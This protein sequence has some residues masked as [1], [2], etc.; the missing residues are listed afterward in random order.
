MVQKSI[1]I[2]KIC[3]QKNKTKQ[4]DKEGDV[5]TIAKSSTVRIPN[6]ITLSGHKCTKLPSTTSSG[7]TSYT[8]VLPTITSYTKIPFPHPRSLTL[9]RCV[10]R[11]RMIISDK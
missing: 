10:Q 6:P 4:K 3:T 11:P 8:T 5:S 9:D 2:F 7:D 1:I